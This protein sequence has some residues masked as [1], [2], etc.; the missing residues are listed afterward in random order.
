MNFSSWNSL[1]EPRRRNPSLLPAHVIVEFERTR[2]AKI[3]AHKLGAVGFS[4]AA[5]INKERQKTVD[6]EIGNL[7]LDG[8]KYKN[9]GHVF[10]EDVVIPKGSSYSYEIL[11]HG[12]PLGGTEHGSM[13]SCSRSGLQCVSGQGT[14]SLCNPGK[15]VIGTLERVNDSKWKYTSKNRYGTSN[16][17]LIYYLP[18]TESVKLRTVLR[19]SHVTYSATGAAQTIQVTRPASVS[20]TILLPP[21]FYFSEDFI[22]SAIIRIDERLNSVAR[23]PTVN[24]VGVEDRKAK[25]IQNVV[26]YAYPGTSEGYL[27]E[28]LSVTATEEIKNALTDAFSALNPEW[29]GRCT[30]IIEEE[31]LYRFSRVYSGLDLISVVFDRIGVLFESVI[32]LTRSSLSVS[33]LKYGKELISRPVYSR[34]P[35]IS[36][37]YRSDPS[38]SDTETPSQWLTSGVDEFL[39][40]KKDS[41]ASFYADYLDPDSCD[42]ALLDWLAQ[43]VGLFGSLWNPAWDKEIKRAMIRNA[44]GWWDRNAKTELPGAGEV[45]T[46]K[47]EALNKFPFANPEWVEPQATTL[48]GVD[49]LSW[50]SLLSWSGNSDNLLLVKLDEIQPISISGGEV[51]YSEGIV[52]I[53]TFSP[54]TNKVSLILTDTPRVDKSTW[55]GLIEAKGSLLGVLFLS[56]VLGLKSHSPLELQVIDAERKILRPRTGLRETEIQSSVL[57]PYKHDSLQVG[58]VSDAESGNLTNQ[59]IAGISR[60]SSAE[61]SRNVFFRVPY[62]YNR[63]GRSWDKVSYIASNWMPSNLNVRVQ[64]AYLSADLWAVGDAFFEPEII[65]VS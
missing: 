6:R 64:Y 49:Q 37:G 57:M 28:R 16:T 65:E 21:K 15:C 48:W 63:D 42:P 17:P 22:D 7:T 24:I 4:R 26:T 39:S 46:P 2:R 41:I 8:F 56:S 58:T 45:L 62:Y 43:H 14:N 50:N 10:S 55:N 11:A 20:S 59:L 54:T 30:A 29:S 35:G 52:N 32:Q 40:K 3:F 31:F 19:G 38:F 12:H 1:K 9:V 5:N 47:G 51:V 61:D 34:L 60:V 44:F 23:K 25:F 13:E 36:E 53:K 27:N 33:S 18:D